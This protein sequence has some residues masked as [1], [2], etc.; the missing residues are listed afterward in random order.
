MMPPLHEMEGKPNMGIAFDNMVVR[1]D[2]M[3]M[4]P[5]L[6]PTLARFLWDYQIELDNKAEQYKAK[7]AVSSGLRTQPSMEDLKCPLEEKKQEATEL[8]KMQEDK[9]LWFMKVNKRRIMM[10]QQEEEDKR[11]I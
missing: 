2:T 1:P 3:E 5:S 9:H 11:K 7:Y 8:V 10:K 6:Y 4:I